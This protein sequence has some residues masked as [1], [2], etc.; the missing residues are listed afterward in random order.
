MLI[1]YLA[2]QDLWNGDGI[3]VIDPHGDLVDD[4]VAFTPKERAKDMIIFDPA[5][6]DRPM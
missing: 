5:D 4:I 6:W 2:R 3:C 1:G